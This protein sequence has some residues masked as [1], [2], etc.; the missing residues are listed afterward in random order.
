MISLELARKLRE[1]TSSE[2]KEPKQNSGGKS[3]FLRA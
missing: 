2:K 3:H 1:F